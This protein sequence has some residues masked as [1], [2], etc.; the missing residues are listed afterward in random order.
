[1]NCPACGL[2]LRISSSYVTVE[3]GRAVTIQ[4]LICKNPKCS[5]FKARVPVGRIRHFH[6]DT[7]TEDDSVRMHC[8]RT[9]A[10]IDGES[11][12]VAAGLENSVDGGRLLVVCPV[13]GETQS[14]D[15]SGLSN[16]N[17]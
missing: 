3:N 4:E 5:F 11:F 15:I 2:Q 14:Y 9:L 17:E 1:M 8:D 10:R 16:G 13:C 12:F 7:H 6:E